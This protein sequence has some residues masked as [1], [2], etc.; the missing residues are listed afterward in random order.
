MP[1]VI[2]S[3]TDPVISLFETYLDNKPKTPLS[4]GEDPVV[5]AC[6]AHRLGNYPDLETLQPT[7]QDRE[8]GSCVR[9]HFMN[10]LVIQRLQGKQ[11]S[12]FREKLGAFLA[13]NRPLYKDEIG[14]LY[15]LPYFYFE[16][17]AREDLIATT[18][19]VQQVAPQRYRVTL[20]PYANFSLKRRGGSVKQYWW[21]D[22][23]LR[24]YCMNIKENSENQL[25][26]QSIWDFANITVES[27][28]YVKSFN[29]TDRFH[30]KLVG[31]RLLEVKHG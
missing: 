11:P 17:L 18:T 22:S 29:G 13:D 12:A 1:N 24:P 8:L 21:V 26:Y 20:K 14:M 10:K 30:Y 5:L 6:T 25:L 2:A 3:D 9:K 4:F 27:H 16:D 28:M 31:P 23:D 15:H 19:P 7:D